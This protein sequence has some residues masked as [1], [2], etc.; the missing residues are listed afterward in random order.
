MSLFTA[1][2]HQATA[3]LTPPIVTS[4]LVLEEEKKVESIEISTKVLCNC[5]LYTKTIKNAESQNLPRM[6]EIA[7]N[8]DTPA[9]GDVAIIMYDT[10][11]H[12]AIV[13]EVSTSSIK[14]RESNY[15]PCQES[16]RTLSYDYRRLV[17]FYRP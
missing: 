8:V 16:E 1:P 17:G 9:V 4:E 10:I 2:I 13:T 14:V 12:V 15:H 11:K 6:A 3:F 5:Y 7:P